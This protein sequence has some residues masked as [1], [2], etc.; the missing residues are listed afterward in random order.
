[1]IRPTGF[2]QKMK[3]PSA[4]GLVSEI[5]RYS[6]HDGPGIR[7]MIFLK[8]C[9]F[10]C[11]WCCNPESKNPLPLVGYHAGKC[12]GCQVCSSV[13]PNGAIFFNSQG[14]M[15]INRD[16]CD[17]CGI[18]VDACPSG[19]LRLYGKIM[20]V[21]EVLQVVNRDSLF[22][23]NSGGGVTISGGEPFY[24]VDFLLELLTAFK[25]ESLN[26]AIETTGYAPWS[27]VNKVLGYLDY[28][29]YDLKIFDREKHLQVL[30]VDNEII[31]QNLIRSSQK[32]IPI[33]IRIP[34]IPG[35]TDDPENIDS[36]ARFIA[37]I[38]LI[39]SV[40]LLPYHRIGLS[41]YRQISES[42][43]MEQ[44]ELPKKE[45]LKQL[46]D[47]LKNYNLTVVIGG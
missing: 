11:P 23:K 3:A 40:H 34:I 10:T 29:L 12:I 9:S 37:G 16:K 47:I 41:K 22:Y 1:M 26:T 45:N 6:V 39:R 28:L 38:D 4:Q 18:C 36:I 31:K 46:A 15:V 35:Y 13:C 33:F 21:D 42:Y 27:L 17:A 8:G 14:M 30:G 32:G 25:K 24:Q 19:A 2:N 5:Q 20:T 7:T 44:T 43:F